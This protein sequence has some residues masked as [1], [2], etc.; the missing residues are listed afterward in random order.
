[1]LQ[2]IFSG[3]TAKQAAYAVGMSPQH[4]TTILGRLG[5]R[6]QYV[7]ASEFQQILNHRKAGATK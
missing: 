7:T 4:A 5:I 6:K 1:M 3:E 2:L